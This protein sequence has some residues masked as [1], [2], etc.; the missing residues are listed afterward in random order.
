MRW[1]LLIALLPPLPALASFEA[2]GVALGEPEAEVRKS[3]PNA[4]CQPLEWESLA[5][6][7]RCDDSRAELGGV[8]VRIT[9]YLKKDAVEAFEARFDT[10]DLERFLEV[11]RASYGKPAA[12][13]RHKLER[14]GKAPREL[15]RA[16]W[17]RGPARAALRSEAGNRRSTLF[18]SRGNFEEEIYRVR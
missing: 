7:R 17:K 8:R 3:Y 4:H 16:Q 6:D 9:F 11:L 1:M 2:N 5:A 10:R 12:E 18:V 14:E 13:G 15:F